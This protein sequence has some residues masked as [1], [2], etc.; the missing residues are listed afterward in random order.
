MTHLV[1]FR[2]Q[3]C[4]FRLDVSFEDGDATFTAGDVRLAIRRGEPGEESQYVEAEVAREVPDEVL[5]LLREHAQATA[6]ASC[7]HEVTAPGQIRGALSVAEIR[8]LDP[9]PRVVAFCEDV[10]V[11]LHQAASRLVQ[12]L[13]WIFNRPW[14]SHPLAGPAVEW[15][16]DGE[17]WAGVP[18]R[19][20]D[21]ATFGGD[22]VHL[23]PG[24]EEL[25]QGLLD[26]EDLSEPLARQIFLEAVALQE[27][28]ARAAVVI[29]VTA[30]EVG[31]KQ[32]AIHRT[33]SPSEK[34]LVSETERSPSLL[35]LLREYLPNLTGQRT[36]DGR[37]VP[38][39]LQEVLER[40]VAR[41]DLIVHRGVDAPGEE[42]VAEM[43]AAVNDLLYL[44]DWFADH[45]W[46]YQWLQEETRAAF[47][48]STS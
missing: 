30:A 5:R 35:R 2:L 32:F 1:R 45:G 7:A 17:R 16:L 8:W 26:D 12:L 29:A 3:A 38:L 46:A 24:A 48:R 13:R 9:P 37:V 44:L 19:P 33:P 10:T 47:D 28:E 21:V 36:T 14:T 23:A 42:D 15:S 25:L 41:R 40:A 27:S 4:A 39:H 34:W 20:V 43:L 31:V 22:E 11:E 18:K 6:P